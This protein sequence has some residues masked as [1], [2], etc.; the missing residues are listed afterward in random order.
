MLGSWFI[1]HYLLS[2]LVLQSSH[3][4]IL[5]LVL[6]LVQ[7]RKTCPD[8]TEKLLTGTKESKQTRN[9]SLGKLE[10]VALL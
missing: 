3:W 1:I 2:F 6:V 8:M 9:I 4:S 7:S 5:C 10:L